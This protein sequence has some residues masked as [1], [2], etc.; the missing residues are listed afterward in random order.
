MASLA[1]Q[2]ETMSAAF[3]AL[4]DLVMSTVRHDPTY[5]PGNP[6]YNV[7]ITL[8]HMHL[9][10]RKSETSQLSMTGDHLSVNSLGF[11]GMLLVKN[12][13]EMEA[14]KTEGIAKILS[15]VALPSVHDLQ[16]K[17]TSLEV[18]DMLVSE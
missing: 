4:L 11:A 9:I 1:E 8:E 17:G 15:S 6:S 13:I 12:D 16:V 10:P 2:R 18:E 5:P 3:V 14:V 7:I